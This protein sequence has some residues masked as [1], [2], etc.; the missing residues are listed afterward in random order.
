MARGGHG[1]YVS[2][3]KRTPVRA[4]DQRIRGIRHWHRLCN[5]IGLGVYD[6]EDTAA[7]TRAR[8]IDG[9]TIGLTT[10]ADG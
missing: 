6:G 8:H 9:F 2:H 1:S 5:G 3:V 7:R 4:D 10:T